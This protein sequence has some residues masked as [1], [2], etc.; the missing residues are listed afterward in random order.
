MGYSISKIRH[1]MDHEHCLATKTWIRLFKRTGTPTYFERDA[2]LVDY[3]QLE[4][5]NNTPSPRA[6]KSHLPLHLLPVD[7]WR[8]QPKIIYI[9]RNPK[10]VAV[11]TFHMISDGHKIFSGSIEDYFDLFMDN[12]TLFAPHYAHV[13]AYWELR[14]WDNF[15][16]LTYEQLLNDR[17]DEVKKIAKF[18]ESKYGE[19]ELKQLTE[20]ASFGNM[21]KLHIPKNDYQFFR[22]GKA[23]GFFDEMTENYIKKFDEWTTVHFKDSD[24]KFAI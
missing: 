19:D 1:N 13:L 23:G 17:F 21:Q 8:V 7:L 6:I 15:L 12:R 5:L 18:L 20:Y 22:K 9:A 14:N 4:K 11:S 3:G 16:F 10:D 24:F 2:F